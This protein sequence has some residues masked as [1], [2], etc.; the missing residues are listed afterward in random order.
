[1]SPLSSHKSKVYITLISLCMGSHSN[2]A[3]KVPAGKTQTTITTDHKYYYTSENFYTGIPNF[4]LLWSATILHCVTVEISPY[5]AQ[6]ARGFLIDQ[7]WSHMKAGSLW[8]G[9]VP[10]SWMQHDTALRLLGLVPWVSRVQCSIWLA[11]QL[12][13]C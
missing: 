7:C 2:C 5:L 13:C 9:L 8:F 6:W 4:I 12:W 1:M 3:C 10:L 11:Q